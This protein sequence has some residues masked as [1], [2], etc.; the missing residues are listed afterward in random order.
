MDLRN[1]EKFYTFPQGKTLEN[2][3]K[4]KCSESN[5]YI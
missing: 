2:I 4:N 3:L 1:N 5:L